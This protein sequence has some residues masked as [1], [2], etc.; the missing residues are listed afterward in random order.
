MKKIY[1]YILKVR[2]ENVIHIP[3]G[4]EILKVGRQQDILCVWMLCDIDM[5]QKP[6]KF[7]IFGTGAE[8]PDGEN[9]TYLDTVVMDYFVW[10]VY[11]EDGK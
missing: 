7:R 2:D 10:H 3:E 9:L 6:H 5:P 11:L 1:K 8:V 4:A